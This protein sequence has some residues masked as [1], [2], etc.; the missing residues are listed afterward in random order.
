M[1]KLSES[2]R[3]SLVKKDVTEKQKLLNSL[4]GSWSDISDN[5]VNELL[6]GKMVIE[7]DINFD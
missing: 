2:V 5:E 3:N 4:S 6:N 7:K 1:A